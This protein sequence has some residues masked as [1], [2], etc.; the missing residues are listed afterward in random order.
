MDAATLTRVFEPFFTT[1][2]VGKGSG[3][4]LSMVQGMAAQSGGG[5][6]ISSTVGRGT[7]VS[8]YLPRAEMM[9]APAS[10]PVTEVMQGDGKVVLLVDD[11]ALVRAGIEAVLDMLGYRVLAVESG[12]AA[13]KLLRDG[14]AVDVLVTDYAMAGM[15]GVELT[16]AT[17]LLLPG[18]P[19]LLITGYTDKPEGIEGDALLHKPFRPPELAARL[20]AILDDNRG[21][22]D[23]C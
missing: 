2:E 16:R 12:R 21:H 4:G 20:F 6:Q 10:A 9:T 22:S 15:S 5:V 1:K 23:R 13:L 18:L 17:R 3:L 11:D 8:I 14:V 7:T 19:V